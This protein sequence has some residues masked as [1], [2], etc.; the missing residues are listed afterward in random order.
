MFAR[1][2]LHRSQNIPTCAR[3]PVIMPQNWLTVSIDTPSARAN[4][5]G[6]LFLQFSSKCGRPG[7]LAFV[8]SNCQ[9]IFNV[10]MSIY[11]W[12]S[13]ISLCSTKFQSDSRTHN[14]N[15]Y[16]HAII[17]LVES[18]YY[19]FTDL[20]ETWTRGHHFPRERYE[21]SRNTPAWKRY[22]SD[23]LLSCMVVSHCDC[24][25]FLFLLAGDS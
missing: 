4:L 6:R 13:V 20:W 25:S 7:L 23:Y 3:T 12:R 2:L 1:K 10:G 9:R 5:R 16:L 21:K 14:Q 19:Q 22:T 18:Y 24:D 11:C 8:I 17:Y 15:S